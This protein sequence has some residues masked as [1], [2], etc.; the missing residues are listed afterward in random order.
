ML[1]EKKGGTRLRLI[2]APM[3]GAGDIVFRRF[4]RYS[5]DGVLRTS[6]G[7]AAVGSDSKAIGADYVVSEMICARALVYRDPATAEM[8]R[9]AADDTP[10]ALQIFGSEPDIMAYATAALCSGG[11]KNCR[12]EAAP[13][14]IDINLGCPV[15]KIVANGEGSALAR[16]VNA[17]AA[18]VAACVK[19]AEPYSIPVT[20]KIRAGWD[21]DHINCAELSRACEA[22]GAA[23]ITVHC[24]TREQFYAPSADWRYAA[25]VKEAVRIPVAVNGDIASAEDALRALEISGADDVAIARGALGRPWLFADIK[26]AIASPAKEPIK[27]SPRAL[28]KASLD[29]VAAAVAEKGEWKGI[30][31]SRH[32]VSAFLH[33]FE[34]AAALRDAA[35]R[36]DT[37]EE[38]HAILTASD[39]YKKE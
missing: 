19:A 24:R 11:Y 20:V 34:G 5:S 18:V 6:P 9:I 35:V 15:K 29:Y 14:A 4:C 8:A 17:A 31:E 23:A 1:T 30:R 25:M 13:A 27:P 28:I 39:A 12:S 33:G 7:I 38:L 2:L 36:A 32:H 16:D 3:A 10:L 26:A 21:S 37:E 22:A